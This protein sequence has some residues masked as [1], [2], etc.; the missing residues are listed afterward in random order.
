MNWVKNGETAGTVGQAKRIEAIQ[1]KLEP[2]TNNIS[3]SYKVHVQDVG[4]Q[5]WLNGGKTA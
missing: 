4:W 3:V 5:N 1:I 2:V